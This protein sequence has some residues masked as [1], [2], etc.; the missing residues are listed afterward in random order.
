MGKQSLYHEARRGGPGRALIDAHY[1]AI[2]ESNQRPFHFIHGYPRYLEQ[3]I[4]L[5]IPVTDFK[6]DIHLSAQ[7]KAWMSQV[8]EAG[9]KDRFWIVVAGGKRDFTAKWWNPEGYQKVVNHFLGRILFVQCGEIGHW[10]GPLENVLS[11]VG[12]TD[13]RQFVR[14]VYHADGV[15]SPVTFAMHLGAA[16]ESKPGRPRTGP[17][18]WSPADASRLTGRLI[19]TTSS[20]A[21][22]GPCHAAPTAAAGSRAASWSPTGT[23]NHD[24]C[25]NFVQLAPDLRIPRCM[26]MITADDVIRRI[27]M[28]YEGGLGVQLPTIRELLRNAAAQNLARRDWAGRASAL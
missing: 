17:A 18:S 6:G 12:K 22:T 4:G 11:L 28:Y 10:H 26:A 14:L 21:P 19:R 5:P 20:S 27:E 3:Q 7:E 2:Q 1:P 9:F 25:R 24:P 15:L 16:V 23:T 8:E 13:I